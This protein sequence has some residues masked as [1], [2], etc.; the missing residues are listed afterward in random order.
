MT[1][2]STPA[3]LEP[4]SHLAPGPTLTPHEVPW[5]EAPPHHLREYLHVLYKHRQVAAAVFAVCVGIAILV[6]LLSPRRYTAAM[7]LEVARQSPIQLRLEKSVLAL[8]ESE[9]DRSGS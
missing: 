9:T 6:T 3:L 4:P 1:K 5:I 2:A 8:D 7:R